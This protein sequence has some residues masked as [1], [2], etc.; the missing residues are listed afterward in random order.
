M[1]LVRLSAAF[2]S[3]RCLPGQGGIEPDR[4]RAGALE[5]FVAGR[6][7]PG[8]VGGGCQS[9]HAIQLPR[10]IYEMNPSQ[11]LCN[12]AAGG[13]IYGVL[14]TLFSTLLG[15]RAFTQPG[16]LCHDASSRINGC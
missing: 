15:I 6:P 5:R 14:R 16:K 2:A 12:R 11:D 8:L 1:T 7:V 4:Q 3:R 10:W 13:A 9:A